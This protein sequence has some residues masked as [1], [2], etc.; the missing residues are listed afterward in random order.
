MGKKRD[1]SD[2]E[3]GTVV[4]ARWADLGISETAVL[5]ELSCKTIYRV[6]RK[7]SGKEKIPSEWQFS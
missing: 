4:G 7:R 3:H 2:L 5:L 1:L 6:Y